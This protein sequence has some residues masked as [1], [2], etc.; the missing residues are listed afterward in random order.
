LADAQEELWRERPASDADALVWV[1]YH[2]RCAKVY[3]QV[4]T[5]D[6]EHRSEALTCAG[7]EIRKARDIEYRLNPDEEDE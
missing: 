5:V 2:R 6:V 1:D 4:S 3:A 7:M